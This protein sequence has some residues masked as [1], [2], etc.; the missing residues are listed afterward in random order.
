P[1][2]RNVAIASVSEGQ[3]R[4]WIRPLDSI[5]AQVLQGTDDA[6]DPFWS[7]DS[8]YIGFFAQGKLKKIALTGGPPLTLCDAPQGRGGTWSPSGVILFAPNLTGG[9]YKVS[10]AG[11]V[12]EAATKFAV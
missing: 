6:S 9:L 11:G 12:P 1:D 4:L 2:G 10:A 7:P 3:Y 5:Q 8:A